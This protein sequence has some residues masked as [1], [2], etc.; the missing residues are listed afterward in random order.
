MKLE[1]LI[2]YLADKTTIRGKKALQKLVYFCAEA[3]VPIYANFRLH[4]YGPYSN[5]VAEELGEAVTR[6]IVK[7]SPDG[8]SF[9]KGFSG[10]KYLSRDYGNIEANREKIQKVLDVFGGFTP[11]ELELYATI[12]FIATALSEAYGKV[13]KERVVNEVY[14]AKGDKFNV[15]RI[16]SAYQDLSAWNWIA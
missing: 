6:E 11:L 16:E 12:H 2:A 4:I 10:D 1:T 7:V 3:G 5:E 8:Y 15:E 14:R 13:T 9:S